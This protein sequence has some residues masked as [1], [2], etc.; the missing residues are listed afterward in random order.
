MNLL[1][2]VAIFTKKEWSKTTRYYTQYST[3]EQLTNN[4]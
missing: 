4:S 3:L 2:K 1:R